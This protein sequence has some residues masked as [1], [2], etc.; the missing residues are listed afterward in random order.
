MPTILRLSR[1]LLLATA[2]F[3]TPSCDTPEKHALRELHRA[4]VQPSGRALV[5]AVTDGEDQH[6]RWLLQLKV[7]TEQRDSTGCTPLRI[8]AEQ[9]RPS[10]AIMLLDA[11]AD[12]E[13]VEACEVSDA[14]GYFADWFPTL[15]EAAEL[16]IPEGLDGES[17]WPVITGGEA[18]QEHKPM[19][20]VY[21]QYGGQVAVMTGRYKMLRRGLQTKQPGDWEVYDV[22]ADRG[23]T[24]DL[25]KERPELIDTAMEVLRKEM[26]EN[27]IFPLKVPGL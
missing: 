12:P 7:H 2:L 22:V 11:G 24:K 13:H 10:V 25:A 14:P 6:V 27:K 15:C 5:E 17:L 1:R 21:P 26:G 23:E 8:A 16:E 19:V 9:D 18:A 3:L 4:G 20:W